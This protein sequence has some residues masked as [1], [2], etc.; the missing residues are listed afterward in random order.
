MLYK[1]FKALIL[2]LNKPPAMKCI[3]HSKCTVLA[4]VIFHIHII[5]ILVF[6]S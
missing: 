5:M 1:Y 3:M 6:I 2:Y 4:Y